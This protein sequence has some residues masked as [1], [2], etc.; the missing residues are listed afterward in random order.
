MIYP[1]SWKNH[2]P[3]EPRNCCSVADGLDTSGGKAIFP[4]KPLRVWVGSFA[5]LVDEMDA[6]A[7]DVGA[8][9]RILIELR[10]LCSPVERVLPVVH[11]LLQIPYVRAIVPACSLHFVGPARAG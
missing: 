2:P 9:L 1:P 7:I 8:K 11:Q 5:A 6:Y 4:E 10:L 3:T